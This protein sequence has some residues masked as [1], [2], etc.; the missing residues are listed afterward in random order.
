REIAEAV[1]AGW[2]LGVDELRY[3]PEGGG[4]YHWVAHAGGA[5]WFVT[6][7]DLDTKPWLGA[8]RHTVFSGLGA[9]YGT[10]LDL[11]AAALAFVAPPVRTGAGAPPVRADERPSVSV[12]PYVDGEPGRWG[13]PLAAGLGYELVT[14]LARLHQAAPPARG[15]R[16]HGL[17]VPGRA[18]LEEA[19]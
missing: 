15:L 14:R 13:P 10:A 8:D 2:G 16:R 6:C 4:A 17:E 3:L 11:R 7:D 19:L 9:A 5:R 1:E 12:F 18:G